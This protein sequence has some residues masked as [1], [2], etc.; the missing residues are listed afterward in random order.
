MFWYYAQI[1]VTLDTWKASSVISHASFP[2]LALTENKGVSF[3]NSPMLSS[4]LDSH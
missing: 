4:K 3:P 2:Q 1:T